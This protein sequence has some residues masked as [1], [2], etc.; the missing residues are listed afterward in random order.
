[1]P[2]RSSILAEALQLQPFLKNLARKRIPNELQCKF[3]PS[4]IFQELLL[5]LSKEQDTPRFR[6]EDLRR[7]WLIRAF[8][9]NLRD[10]V[11]AFRNTA[12]RDVSHEA[13]FDAQYIPSWLNR[14]S[15]RIHAAE[16]T[17]QLNLLLDSLPHAYQIVLRWHYLEGLTYAEI[18]KRIQRSEDAVRMTVKRAL[19][20]ASRNSPIGTA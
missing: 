15:E 7:N 6:T 17:Q 3:T 8:L 1:M 19:N 4:D 11:R 18:G 10:S 20:A 9:N 14:A 2:A 5:D 12:K 16:R 13:P